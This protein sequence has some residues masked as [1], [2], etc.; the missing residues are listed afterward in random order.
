MPVKSGLTDLY[1]TGYR[2]SLDDGNSWWITGDRDYVHWID[3]MAA[4]M[5]LEECSHNGSPGLIFSKIRNTSDA[6]HSQL[7]CWSDDKGWAACDYKTI[8]IWSH[9]YIPDVIC[10]VKYDEDDIAKYIGMRLSL[11]PIYQGSIYSG[12][13]PFHAALA[14]LKGRG[15][16]LV[17]MSGTGK[18]TCYRRLP[19]YWKPLCDDEVLV[20]LHEQKEYRA[21]PFPTWSDYLWKRRAETWN[22]HYSA[23]LLAVFFLEQSETDEVVPIGKGEAAFLMSE[24]AFQVCK[25]FF[26]K[27]NIED[28]REFKGKLF[29]NACAIAK[30]VPAFRLNI[31]LHGTFWKEIE[32]AIEL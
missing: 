21:H 7:R 15:V 32:K 25:K 4:I 10:E 13:L 12:G 26:R 18:S 20:V 1:H 14:E 2:L 16:L 8:R 19:D 22:T 11:K 30:M 23:T 3:E 31:S 17:A 28:Q 9:R 6:S 29:S 24:S 5:E 27:E